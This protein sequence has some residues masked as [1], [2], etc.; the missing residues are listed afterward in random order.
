MQKQLLF[1]FLLL[2]TGTIMAQQ[3]NIVLFFVDDLGWADMN[4]S[5]SGY[6]TPNI[7]ILKSEGL[8]FSR[9]YVSTATS[10]PSRASLLTGKEALRCGFVRHIYGNPEKAEFQLLESDPGHMRSRAWLP[11]NEI[12]YA[13]RLKDYGYYNYHIG[14]W[15]LGHEEFYPIHQ[16]FDGMYGV[17]D[18]GNPNSYYYP[19]FRNKNPFSES[20]KNMYLTDVLTDEAER[21]INGYE[22]E[23]PFLLNIWYYTVH[24]PHVGRVDLV[25][26][27]KSKGLD[28]KMANYAAMVEA[29]DE[30]VGRIRA[31]VNDK[32]ISDNTIFIFISDQGGTFKN[33]PL[34][35]GKLGGD[36]LAEGGSRVPMIIYA[37][38]FPTMGTTCDIPV[39]TI[40]IFPTLVELASGSSCKDKQINGVSLLP[41]LNGRKI[42]ERDLFLHRSY[43]DQNAA[44]IRGDWKLIKYRSGKLELYNLTDDIG[45]QNNLVDKYPRRTK[46]MLKR[47]DKWLDEATPDELLNDTG[48]TYRHLR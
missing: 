19:Y 11:L 26:K 36:A 41:I 2:N 43:E 46:K 9:A 29:L 16:G 14:K 38:G 31:A 34:R 47:L 21:F 18:F 42:K 6:D 28:E 4:Y 7:D 13:E 35:G 27:Y 17:S 3:P 12:T 22:K 48:S 44:V 33:G 40:D 39:Q 23:S 5:G 15:H 25:Q 30:S 24:E 37:P 8:Y 1:S 45:E 20:F 32:G 10:S